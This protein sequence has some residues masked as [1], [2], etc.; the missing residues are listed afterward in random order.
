MEDLGFRHERPHNNDDDDDNSINNYG[1]KPI[2]VLI[3]SELCRSKC[4]QHFFFHLLVKK[5]RT[6]TET[7]IK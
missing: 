5:T 7:W 4:H 1:N 2:G 3:G 6:N